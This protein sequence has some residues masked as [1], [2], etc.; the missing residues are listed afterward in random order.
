MRR[1][2]VSKLS[3][4][5]FL[6][7]VL[8]FA[9][10]SDVFS[11]RARIIVVTH[12]QADDAFWN[13]IKNGIKEASRETRSKTDYRAPATINMV[14]MAR[15]IDAAVAQKPDG[16]V[17]SIPDATALGPSIRKAVQAGIPVISINSGSD[18]YEELGIAA[19]V[20]QTEYEA[21][22]GAG[23]KMRSMGVKNAICWNHEVGNV[24]LEKRCQGFKDGLGGTS[25][26]VNVEGYD[27]SKIRSSAQAELRKDSSIQ[28]I[29]TLSA[30]VGE[31]VRDAARDMGKLSSV[32]IASFDLST[33][34]VESV[35]KGEMAFLVDQQPYLQ[36]YLPVIILSKYKKYGV[37]PAGVVMTG[38]GFVTKANA[39]QVLKWAKR[40]YR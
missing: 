33:T 20:G 11:Q 21:G 22:R 1:K 30:F 29:L 26:Q 31:A 10:G 19:H 25:R 27:P 6:T 37:L 18:V 23:R 36:G 35:D 12:G 9:L 4:A 39:R 24:S 5:M 17:V 3:W 13:R 8:T 34:A 7:L 16:I 38:P 32:K 40:E 2:I 28:G 14:D 15:L